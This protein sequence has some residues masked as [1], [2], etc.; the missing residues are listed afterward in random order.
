MSISTFAAKIT[1]KNLQPVSQPAAPVGLS[2]DQIVNVTQRPANLHVLIPA[3]RAN[4]DLCKILLSAAILGYPSPVIINWKRSFDENGKVDGGAQ[5]AKISGINEYISH[6]DASHDDDLV[7]MVDSQNVWL[8]LRPQTLIDRFYDINRRADERIKYELGPV[9]AE[10]HNLRQE[11]VFGSQKRCV[12]FQAEDAACYAVP[13]SIL[14]VDIYGPTTDTGSEDDG[15]PD[16][17]YRQRYLESGVA[18]GRLRAMRKLFAQAVAQSKDER[19]RGS[20]QYIFSH[21]FGNQEVWRE[22]LRRDE[23]NATSVKANVED[24][25]NLDHIDEVRG[26]AASHKDRNFE[27]GIGLDYNSEITFNTEYAE[28]DAEWVTFADPEQLSQVQL[29][30]G[31]VGSRRS[32]LKSVAPD[33]ANTAPPFWTFGDEGLHRC[34]PWSNVSLF[35]NV[36]T[37]VTPVAI[38]HTAHRDNRA[39]R[40][41]NWWPLIWFQRHARLLLDITIYSPVIPVAVSGYDDQSRREWWSYELWRGGARNG[42]SEPGSSGGGWLKF[43]DECRGYHKDLFRDGKGPWE[44]PEAH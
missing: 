16:V 40:R 38:H 39:S 5:L 2:I 6:L 27:F 29:S 9:L 12:P 37:A 43:D 32:R 8:Q 13:T 3:S 11:I 44:L 23:A 4:P 15:N 25:F 26:K 33:I 28:N 41:E 42:L 18:V 10:K 17:N 21:I 31:I 20:D 36:W 24:S 1:A 19:N 14:P 22:I 30:R 35:T 34:L 7:L